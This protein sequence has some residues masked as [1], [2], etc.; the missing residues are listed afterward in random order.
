MKT[1][2]KGLTLLFCVLFVLFV[3]GVP[4]LAEE[5]VTI[6]GTVNALYQI[7][8]E[9]QQVYDVAESEKGDEVAE[10]VGQK[11]KVTG[12]VEEQDDIKVIMVS[13]YEVIEE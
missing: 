6:L 3:S 10:M 5:Q 2:R 4:A 8:T 1:N 12:T 11:V 9:D 13:A 7:V